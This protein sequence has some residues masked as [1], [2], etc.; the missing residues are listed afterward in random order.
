MCS[1]VCRCIWLIL[2][3]LRLPKTRNDFYTKTRL[4]LEQHR[5]NFQSK[6]EENEPPA[7]IYIYFTILVNH[8]FYTVPF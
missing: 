2:L 8:H 4:C 6:H 7:C 5:K 1:I 3:M